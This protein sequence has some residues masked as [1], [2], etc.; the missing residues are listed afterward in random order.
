MTVP[1][2]APDPSDTDRDTDRDTN[3]DTNRDTAA[4]PDRLD[5]GS[6][7][8]VSGSGWPLVIGVGGIAA[9]IWSMLQGRGG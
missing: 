5:V 2:R 6:A 8:D 7:R 3:R 9:V 1:P 4:T